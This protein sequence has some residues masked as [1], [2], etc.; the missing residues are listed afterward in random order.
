MLELHDHDDRDL[1]DLRGWFLDHPSAIRW[2]GPLMRW[3]LTP[4]SFEEDLKL[5]FVRTRVAREEDGKLLAFGQYYRKLNRCHLA[6]I[7]IAP[8][9]RGRGL[10]RSLVQALMTDAKEQLQ[11][12]A[13]SLYVL[14]DNTPAVACYRACGFA[15]AED[16]EPQ[17]A[18]PDC[19]FMVA[20]RRAVSAA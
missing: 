17:P 8:S 16:P 4:D 19:L 7:A 6:R 2:G 3:P 15:F 18:L 11:L 1:D 5:D 20:E 12:D 9:A 14:S 13:C 10:G